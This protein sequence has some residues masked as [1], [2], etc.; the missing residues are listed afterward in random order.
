MLQLDIAG[1][2]HQEKAPTITERTD[3]ARLGQFMTPATVARFMASLFLPRPLQTCR[4]LDAGAG[5]GALSCAFLNRWTTGGSGFASV[6]VTAYEVDDHLRDHLARRLARYSRATS[7]IVAGDYIQ[8]A[9]AHGLRNQGYTHVILNPPYKKISGQSA[10][11]L[12]LRC[13]GIETVNLYSAFVA[14]AVAEAA[15]GGQIVA[16]TPRSFCNGPYYRPFRDFI[17]ARAAI[18]H[19][20]LFASRNQPFKGDQVLQETIIIRLERGGQQ[21]PVTV[22]TSTDDS[23]ADFATHEHPFER[24]VPPN[25]PER[26]IHVPTTTE[27]S[28]IERLS[29]VGYSLADLGIRVSTGPV[30]DFRMKAHLRPMPE[31]GAV[32]L[33]YPSHLRMAGT[34]WPV[35]GLKKP[36]AISRNAE[37]ERWLYPN[38]FYCAVRRFSAKEEKRRVVASIV[39][40]ATFGKH[41]VLGF[42]NHINLFHEN[43]QGL[44]ETLAHGLALFLNTTAVDEHFRCFNG[45]TQVNATDLKLMRYPSRQ[46]LIQLG[47]WAM[48]QGTLTQDQMD[49]KL[50]TLDR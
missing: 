30:V 28:T 31:A 7:R 19:M 34:V 14:L 23:F 25:T 22:S 10:H 41:S 47:K 35:A 27:K 38:D 13:V 46:D 40:P 42:E 3:K 21:G 29:A 9:T 24:I 32:P 36:N 33:I 15:P 39:D 43:K 50:E 5:M 8:L 1:I 12:A 20:H 18:R 26:L 16:I 11:R 37:T 49:A 48:G 45:H 2:L 17:L 4:L 6:E 44:P